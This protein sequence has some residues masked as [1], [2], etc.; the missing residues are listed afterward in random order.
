M[1]LFFSSLSFLFLF[2]KFYYI[3]CFVASEENIHTSLK[4]WYCRISLLGGILFTQIMLQ[5]NTK[6]FYIWAGINL[7]YLLHKQ[8]SYLFVCTWSLVRTSHFHVTITISII[9]I[10]EATFCMPLRYCVNPEG[11]KPIFP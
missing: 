9:L 8:Y 5:V 10:S 4:C 7:K 2:A 1:Y 3:L 11:L 6:H